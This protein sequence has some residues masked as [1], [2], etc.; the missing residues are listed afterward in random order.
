M[1]DL[2]GRGAQVMSH[3]RDAIKRIKH[4]KKVRK[5]ETRSQQVASGGDSRRTDVLHYQRVETRIVV[6]RLHGARGKL[7]IREQV[8]PELKPDLTELHTKACP[9]AIRY[10]CAV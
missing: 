3:V 6:D 5:C 8:M 4:A 10:S 7:R 1:P 9:N 2:W